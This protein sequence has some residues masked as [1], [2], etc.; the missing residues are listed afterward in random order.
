MPC[1]GCSTRR[2]VASLKFTSFFFSFFEMHVSLRVLGLPGSPAC[3][4]PGIV[5]KAQTRSA[6]AHVLTEDRSALCVL[7]PGARTPGSFRRRKRG[8]WYLEE[9]NRTNSGREYT[10]WRVCQSRMAKAMPPRSSWPTLAAP[11][12]VVTPRAWKRGAVHSITERK[13]KQGYG[14]RQS[15]DS[16][17]KGRAQRTH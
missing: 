13:R 3:P 16:R 17:V 1:L 11:M 14:F 8:G 6:R 7:I 9:R 10:S 5:H 15:G 4:G 12:V 2:N